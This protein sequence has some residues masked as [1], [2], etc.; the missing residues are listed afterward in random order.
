MRFTVL[1]D[2]CRQSA[3]ISIGLSSISCQR[4][5]L[6]SCS[7][8]PMLCKISRAI[9]ED[10]ADGLRLIVRRQSSFPLYFQSNA[11]SS[12]AAAHARF[13][14][15]SAMR[16]GRTISTASTRQISLRA[17]V[18]A[19]GSHSRLLPK[20]TGAVKPHKHA[21]HVQAYINLPS[22]G[23]G[24]HAAPDKL[25]KRRARPLRQRGYRLISLHLVLILQCP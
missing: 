15:T 18:P 9:T 19:P 20:Y 8:K 24:D 3:T 22:A 2:T 23:T 14:T 16:Y 5:Q 6:R 10:R 21:R 1:G 4:I 7:G 12:A 13:D 25:L 11:G 17:G